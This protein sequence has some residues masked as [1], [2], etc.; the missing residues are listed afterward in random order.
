MNGNAEGL[1]GRVRPL[2]NLL[3]QYMRT[4]LHPASLDH[5]ALGGVPERVVGFGVFEL[6][7]SSSILPA[8][9]N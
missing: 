3:P 7:L 6:A 1:G 2:Q 8:T 5:L 4:V 9:A